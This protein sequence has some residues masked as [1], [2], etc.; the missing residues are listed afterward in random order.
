MFFFLYIAIEKLTSLF[1]I[2]YSEDEIKKA[3]ETQ[4]YIHFVDFLDMCASM[5]WEKCLVHYVGCV[6]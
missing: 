4:A 3:L 2:C 1:N 6:A 5:L